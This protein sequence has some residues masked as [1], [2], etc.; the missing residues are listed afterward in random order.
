MKNRDKANLGQSFEQLIITANQFYLLEKIAAIIK[1]PTSFKIVRK[2]DPI[3]KRSEIVSAFPEVKST[4]DFTGQLR[5]MPVWFEAKSTSNKTSFPLSKIAHHQLEWLEE[6][7]SIG[8]YAFI[9]FEIVQQRA[10]YRMTYKQLKFFMSES[11]RKSIP[12][13][14]FEN[15]CKKVTFNRHGILD[16]LEGVKIERGI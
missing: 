11:D 12:F 8:G 14:Y 7:S 9:L 6:V 1:V 16:Y 5:N 3:R 15:F 10:Y 13:S 4:V 2:Y